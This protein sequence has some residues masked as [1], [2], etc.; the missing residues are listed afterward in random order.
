VL[1]LITQSHKQ[2]LNKYKSNISAKFESR[3]RHF[4]QNRSRVN[5][6]LLR[7]SKTNGA[8][9]DGY[10][11]FESVALGGLGVKAPSSHTRTQGTN[12]L[13]SQETNKVNLKQSWRE[14]ALLVWSVRSWRQ[15]TGVWRWDSPVWAE[16]PASSLL[17]PGE[18]SRRRLCAA[19]PLTALLLSSSLSPSSTSIT[20]W[21]PQ[22][23]PMITITS[24]YHYLLMITSDYH[25]QW[26]PLPV[27]TSDDQ[28]L[29]Y[30]WLPLPVITSDY[31]YQLS[32]LPVITSDCQWL[33]LPVIISDYQWL[34]LLVI[35]GD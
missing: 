23:L 22:W 10:V 20:S 5:L 33:L 19:V 35:T 2:T 8:V 6:L 28:W 30:Q 11:P 24:D 4:S 26:L 12:P 25:H 14:A 27:F 9:Q 1:S 34:P 29:H 18:S 17:P 15:S 31:H 7:P 32:P 16:P 21:W 3:C 13:K